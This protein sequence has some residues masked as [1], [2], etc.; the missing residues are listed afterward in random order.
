M[1][2]QW[3]QLKYRPTAGGLGLL[4]RRQS[5]LKSGGSW[6]RV[7]KSISRHISE[8]FRFFRQFHKNSFFACKFTRNFDLFRQFKKNSI[9]QAN[10]PIYSYFWASYSISLQKSP[11][12]NIHP[13]HDKI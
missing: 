9:F 13:V 2:S 10:L 1:H 12:S 7:K 6:L 11:L 8:K 3:I 4:Q 5:S